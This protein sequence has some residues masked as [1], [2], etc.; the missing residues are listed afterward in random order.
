MI[1][2][3][4]EKKIMKRKEK[5]LKCAEKSNLTKIFPKLRSLK[6]IFTNKNNNKQNYYYFK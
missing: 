4:C 2:F 1:N 5:E 3:D 6:Q